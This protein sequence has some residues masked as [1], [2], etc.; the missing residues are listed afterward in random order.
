MQLLLPPPVSTVVEPTSNGI[1]GDAFA[2]I[3]T[4]GKLYGLNASGPAPREISADIIKDKGYDS[5]PR[6]GWIPVTVPGAPVAWAEL[7]KKFG[8]LPLSEVME[9]AIRY[10]SEGYP[11][12]PYISKLWSKAYMTFQSRS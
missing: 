5:M 7:S 4:K 2:L 11:V 1:G 3:W 12:S 10:A 8:K 6:Y 9:P